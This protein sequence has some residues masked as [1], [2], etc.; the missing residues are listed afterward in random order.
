MHLVYIM[1]RA[2][3]GNPGSGKTYYA[4]N[5]L[6]KFTD[7]DKIYNQFILQSHVCLITNIDDVH[8]NHIS[9]DQFMDW[10]LYLID[11][12]REFMAKYSYTRIIM[13]V[14]EAQ[15]YFSNLKDNDIY[16]FFEYHR[17][18]GIDIILISHN[19]YQLPRRLVSLCEYVIEAMPRIY[20]TVGFKYQNKDSITGSVIF[21]SHLRIDKSVF[22]LY[23]SFE[24]DESV[25][26]TSIVAKKLVTSVAAF[27]IVIAGAYFWVLHGNLFDKSNLRSSQ[28]V[29]AETF[30]YEI[31]KMEI[32]D[33]RM[34][35]NNNETDKLSDNIEQDEVKSYYTKVDADLYQSDDDIIPSGNCRGTVRTKDHIYFLYQ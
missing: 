35:K 9:V 26:P 18:L 4:M 3:T 14:D 12:I 34:V 21:T 6:R 5:Y 24:H 7:Y 16:Y 31:P 17:H 13:I 11:N 22:L 8:V 33:Y 32:T 2:I 1:L 20:R 23:K 25:K 30:E 28:V 27:L 29:K 10:R 15:R 19:I